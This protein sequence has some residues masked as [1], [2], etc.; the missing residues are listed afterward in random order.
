[1]NPGRVV[2]VL[3][4]TVSIIARLGGEAWGWLTT[5]APREGRAYAVALDSG[6]D[7][8]AGG[9]IGPF[10]CAGDFAVVKL[11]GSTGQVLWQV[12]FTGDGVRDLAVDAAGEVVATG[13]GIVVKLGGSDGTE[14]WR[15]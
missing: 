12:G 8:L 15:Q 4:V 13:S 1:M 6:G 3:I 2:G 11:S 9:Y 14:L 5:F 10:C 7:V